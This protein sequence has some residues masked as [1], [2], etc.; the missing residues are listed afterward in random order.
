MHTTAKQF[1]VEL[2]RESEQVAVGK[3]TA[4]ISIIDFLPQQYHYLCPRS[5]A[6][7]DR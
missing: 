5:A 2:K 4:T 7:Q 3:E 1:L 6:R